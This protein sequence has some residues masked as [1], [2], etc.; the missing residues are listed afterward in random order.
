[1]HPHTL[2]SMRLKPHHLRTPSRAAVVSSSAKAARV[3]IWKSPLIGW[4]VSQRPLALPQTALHCIQVWW[5]MQM[6]GWCCTILCQP[7]PRRQPP[8][9]FSWRVAAC[10]VREEGT[11]HKRAHV[12]AGVLRCRKLEYLPRRRM[13]PVGTAPVK[14]VARVVDGLE[15]SFDTRLSIGKNDCNTF[16]RRVLLE[17]GLSCDMV[18]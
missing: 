15:A 17:L 18:Q 16:A 2:S 13:Q 7:T 3:Y 12:S 8:L 10:Q 14:D 9:P 4:S 1:M 5:W 6:E 11:S